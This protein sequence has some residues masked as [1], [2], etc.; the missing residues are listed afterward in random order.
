MS[1]DIKTPELGES[2]TEAVIGEWLKKPGERVEADEALVV[3]E[4]DKVSVEVPAPIAGVLKEIIAEAGAQVAV[5]ALLGRMEEGGAATTPQSNENKA[6]DAT[7]PSPSAP[8]QAPISVGQSETIL[9][10]AARKIAAE[11]NIQ[12]DQISGSGK[13]GVILKED[14]AQPAQQQQMQNAS[15]HPNQSKPQPKPLS[16][17]PSN[18][19]SGQ[20]ERV[21]MSRLRQTIAKRLKQAQNEAAILTTFNEIDM[22]AV[23][24]LRKTY[25]EEFEARHGV[26]L[27]FMSVFVKACIFALR[28]I[29]EVNALIDG[30]HILYR[31]YY[32]IGIAVGTPKG[33]VVPVLH[34]AHMMSLADIEKSIYNYA[35]AARDNSLSLSALQG[36]TFT[37]SNGGVYGSLLSTPILNA[38]Q[39]GILG[40][41]KIEKRPMIV[42]DEIVIRPMMYVALS[43]DHRLVDGQQAVT[44]LVRVKEMVEDPARIV[45]SV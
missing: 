14:L 26:R 4:T 39:S 29:P 5:G 1:Y 6:E 2:I 31:D 3:L 44:F 19:P 23:M 18:Q 17:D 43:Y 9:S 45:L 22:S 30:D 38:P 15:S 34:N 21:K 42:N 32:H 40:M 37:I 13:G 28:E 20:E 11:K 7:S 24:Q 27:G 8:A 25:N 36:G 16:S 41:H 10:P 35:L 12:L 33:L